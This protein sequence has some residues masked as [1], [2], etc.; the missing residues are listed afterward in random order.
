MKSIIIATLMLG[1][2]PALAQS[3]DTPGIDDGTTLGAVTKDFVTKPGG[4]QAHGQHAK[5]SDG[6][7][8]PGRAGLANLGEDLSDTIDII[9]GD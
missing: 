8:G 1:A 2:V 7:V 5:T 3:V 4:G 9:D 6:K